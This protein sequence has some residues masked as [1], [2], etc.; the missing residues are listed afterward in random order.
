MQDLALALFVAL[1]TTGDDQLV[2]LGGDGQIVFGKTGLYRQ[3][4][5]NK[6]VGTVQT[7]RNSKLTTH[8]AI[9]TVLF[10]CFCLGGHCHASD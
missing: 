8:G 2:L 3:W 5:R 1:K 6:A 7:I 9:I 10:F 4:G